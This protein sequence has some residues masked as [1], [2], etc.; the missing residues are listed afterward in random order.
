MRYSAGM[1]RG[2]D[3]VPQLSLRDRK[4]ERTRRALID[5]AAELFERKGYDETTVAQIAAAAE[6][7]TRTFF[8]YFASKEDILFPDSDMR[9]R[10]TIEAIADRDP[11]EGP[12]E[13]LV[14]ALETVAE[15]D[16]DM[17]GPMAA[18][19]M[20]LFRTVPTVRGKA[21]QVQMAAQ[22]QIARELHAA[23]PGE[24]DRVGAAALAGAFTGAVSGALTALM[25]EDDTADGITP[26]AAQLRAR[27]RQATD[28]ALRPWQR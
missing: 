23:F 3:G 13:V 14:R 21:L 18:V 5:A 6:I 8:G 22:Q 25:D 4:R 11:A 7:G 17:V 20:R 24:L 1:G 16:A 12:V 10:T 19:R 9:T 28:L 15:T 26:D 2:A 27:V